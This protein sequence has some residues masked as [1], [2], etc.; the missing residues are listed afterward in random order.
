M[1]KSIQQRKKVGPLLGIRAGVWLGLFV[2][3][4]ICFLAISLSHRS[5]WAR[6]E[7]VLEDM[8]DQSSL[9][10]HDVSDRRVIRIKFN[11][12]VY[13]RGRDDHDEDP[14]LSMVEQMTQDRSTW[15]DDPQF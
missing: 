1:R 12:K 4:L 7:T 5:I 6:A 15:I 10:R 8:G 3:V 14:M 11:P 9:L 2:A 13:E